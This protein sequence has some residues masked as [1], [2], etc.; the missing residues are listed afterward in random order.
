M[1]ERRRMEAMH[2]VPVERL[3]GERACVVLT[4]LR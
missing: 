4:L 1:G 2:R 3:Q